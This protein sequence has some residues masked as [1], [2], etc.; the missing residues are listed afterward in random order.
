MSNNAI[1]GLKLPDTTEASH[2]TKISADELLYELVE[3]CIEHKISP[4][5]AIVE[6]AKKVLKDRQYQI[7]LGGSAFTALMNNPID[8]LM[9]RII[10]V[11]YGQNEKLIVG[12]AFHEGTKYLYTFIKENKKVPSLLSCFKEIV[13]SVNKNYSFIRPDL[14]K[15]HSSKS[16]RH[17]AMKL[18]ATY[19]YEKARANV[20]V[21][22]VE[23]FM[24]LPTPAGMLKNQEFSRKIILS[25]TPD[26][27]TL[28]NRTLYIKDHKTSSL[29]IRGKVE[30]DE[31][32]LKLKDD[33]STLESEKSAL[34]KTVDK[35]KLMPEK[36][37]EEMLKLTTTSA[38]IHLAEVNKK[39]TTAL[40]KSKDKSERVILELREKLEKRDECNHRLQEIEVEL[41]ELQEIFEPIKS[42]FLKEQ[43]IADTLECRKKH[44]NQLSFYAQIFL[45][46]KSA[47]YKD[48]F[49]RIVLQIENTV[50]N[51]KPYVQ[52]F[53]WE[54]D[55]REFRRSA[56][57]YQSAVSTVELLLDGSVSP[58]ILFKHSTEAF[59]GDDTN[60][61]IDEMNQII[62]KRESGL[63]A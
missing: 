45:I 2:A 38:K 10:K 33:I 55:D 4:Q 60:K 25:V 58:L 27:V 11:N 49:D 30:P 29:P 8:F 23:E 28:E 5:R 47:M 53:E 1:A 24:S 50:K 21:L 56:E 46:K 20:E 22:L 44:S 54:L 14:I 62:Y 3:I 6:Y 31:K 15:E 41:T 19:Y 26:L 36:L 17:E 37:K 12:S 52:T 40:N 48:Q 63:V 13:K 51:V 57:L 9:T 59:I 7:Y 34:L 32:Y 42:E 16:L 39:P 61:F 43:H 18:F 35:Y